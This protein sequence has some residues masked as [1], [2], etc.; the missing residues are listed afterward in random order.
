MF[1]QHRFVRVLKSLLA[2]RSPARISHDF[3]STL[4]SSTNSSFF[5]SGNRSESILSSD[6]CSLFLEDLDQTLGEYNYGSMSEAY[7]SISKTRI[8][9]GT[10]S[11]RIK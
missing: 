3:F 6:L 8:E 5:S 10:Q 1:F 11:L 4:S 9:H 7:V 2:V